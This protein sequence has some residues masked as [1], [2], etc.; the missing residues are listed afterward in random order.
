MDGG[1]GKGKCPT[2]CK[3]GGEIVREGECPGE[4]CPGNMS[5]EMSSSRAQSRT[6]SD[7]L[8]EDVFG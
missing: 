5:G 7:T 8:S 6:T 3:K 1:G 4:L 2:L